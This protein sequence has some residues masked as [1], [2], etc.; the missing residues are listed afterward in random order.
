MEII[1]VSNP[2]LEVWIA[3]GATAKTV[4]VVGNV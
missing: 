1:A 2:R 3:R 4:M